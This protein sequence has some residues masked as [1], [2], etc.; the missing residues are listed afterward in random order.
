MV[1]ECRRFAWDVSLFTTTEFSFVRLPEQFTTGSSIMPNKR[2]PDLVELLRA[3]HATVQ[4]AIAEIHDV[5]SLPSGYHRDLQA[6]KAPLVRAFARG[7]EAMACMPALIQGTEFD[8]QRLR[9]AIDPSMHATDHAIDLAREGVPFR[10][11]YRQIKDAGEGPADVTTDSS[12]AARVSPGAAGNLAL[13]KLEH[14]L[15]VLGSD[16]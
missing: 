15:H 13:D 11:A 10:E 9:D 12:I 14:R 2:N 1:G 16:H 6:T 7:L 5:L 4:G 3:A 8:E